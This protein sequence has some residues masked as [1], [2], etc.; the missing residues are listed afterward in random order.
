[1][2]F[3]NP[4]RKSAEPAPERTEP[5]AAAAGVRPAD[6]RADD[7]AAEASPWEVEPQADES[8]PAAGSRPDPFDEVNAALGAAQM[9]AAGASGLAPDAQESAPEPAAPQPDESPA[10]PVAPAFAAVP[11]EPAAYDPYGIAAAQKAQMAEAAEK[12]QAAEADAPKTAAEPE[13]AKPAR[14]AASIRGV[15]INPQDQQIEADAV[16]RTVI[17]TPKPAPEHPEPVR[18]PEL[19]GASEEE[20]AARRRTKHRLVGA[21][22]I[23]VAVVAAAP[24]ILDSGEDISTDGIDPT[25]PSIAETTTALEVPPVPPARVTT[26]DHDVAQSSIPSAGQTSQA[27]L[28]QDALLAPDSAAA[29][30][31][32][33]DAAAAAEKAKAQAAAKKAEERAKAAAQ[34]SADEKAAQKT[35]GI[36]VP[37]GSGYYV[38]VMATSSARE[39]ERVVKNLAALGLPAYRQAVERKAATLWRVRV[40]LYKTKKEADGV[41][42]TIVLNGVA[43]E[44]IVGK[45]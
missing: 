45:Q 35:A 12:A 28:A 15:R 18:R 2:S 10:A 43:A 26:G 4:F 11:P 32:A 25:I 5:V 30:K 21:A 36:P 29:K 41:V 3:F 16:A 33:E 1:M 17:D 7:P 14:G 9:S 40:G 13:R 23:L 31:E 20:L 19:E 37:Q 39:A 44:P 42:G 22:A 24:F 27:N 8:A 34:K 6:D 38:Q